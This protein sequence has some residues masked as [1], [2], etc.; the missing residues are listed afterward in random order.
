[1]LGSTWNVVGDNLSAKF[2]NGSLDSAGAP[3]AANQDLIGPYVS[4]PEP[5]TML[6]GALLLLPFLASGK[7]PVLTQRRKGLED[8][9]MKLGRYSWDPVGEAQV[10]KHL[11]FRRANSNE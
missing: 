11:G 5:T 3:F 8:T 9:K 6:L 10:H 4:T 1:M 2:W 7:E